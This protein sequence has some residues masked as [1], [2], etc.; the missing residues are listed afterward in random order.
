MENIGHTPQPPPQ[1]KLNKVYTL[2]FEEEE[3][4]V[5]SNVQSPI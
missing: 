1:K 5:D 4:S 2:F 3:E